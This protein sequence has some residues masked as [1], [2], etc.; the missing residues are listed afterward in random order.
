M[1]FRDIRKSRKWLSVEEI[2]LLLLALFLLIGLLA[3]N[4]FLARILPGGEQLF[5][6]WSGA[7]AFLE[8]SFEPY[9]ATIAERTQNVAYG[10][11][12]SS[13]EYPY[14]LNDPFHIV[15]LYL[16][17]AWIPDFAVA[18][19]VWMLLSEVLLM[20]L[21]FTFIRSLEWEPPGWLYF[22]LMLS[23]VF[24]YYSLIAIRSG[25]PAIAITF[26]VFLIAY[27]L[28]AFSDELAGASLFLIAYQWEVG[29]LF[30]FFILVF[31]FANRRWR[32]FYGFGMALA[33]LLAI[34]FLSYPGWALPYVRGVLSDWYR[35]GNLTF[36]S[37]ISAIFPDMRFP[38]G[39]WSTVLLGVIVFIEWLGTINS[40][41]RHIVWTVCLS[42]AV[43]PLMGMAVFPSNYVVLV[44]SLILILML[45]WERWKRHRVW[46]SLLVV[47]SAWLVPLWLNYRVLS[48]APAIYSHLLIILPPIATIIGLYWMRWWAF[49]S[50]R[51]WF[52][53]FGD[54]T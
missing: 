47:L 1:A 3:L 14:Y 6:R 40:P 22:L 5:V 50:P 7:R 31:V 52:D 39:L 28:H 48:G 15:L 26:L 10:R 42:L 8:G 25:A 2:R 12:A 24:G 51:T 34:T 30:F 53:K 29:A 9:G 32:V 18:R 17:L 11:D 19:S 13:T 35:S 38:M 43:M 4:L 23:S 27:S 36:G 33:I 54:R 37:I 49:R 46:F 41:Y 44:P 45:I 16:P 21:V 20:L